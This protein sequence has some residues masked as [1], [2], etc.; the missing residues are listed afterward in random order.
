MPC[1]GSS[2]RHTL[3]RKRW[4]NFQN[5]HLKHFIILFVFSVFPSL[6][7][8]VK[9]HLNN[10]CSNQ[11]PLIIF[12]FSSGTLFLPSRPGNS[13]RKP[14]SWS[15][16]IL[17]LFPDD[18]VSDWWLPSASAEASDFPANLYLLFLKYSRVQTLV[19]TRRLASTPSLSKITYIRKLLEH[20]N[21]I[22]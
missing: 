11:I 17:L 16:W 20:Q 13:G 18:K 8:L 6:S 19:Q 9:L 2:N 14:S 22:L 5:W 12:L 3:D 21:R 10:L 1:G 4:N 7:L 15:R